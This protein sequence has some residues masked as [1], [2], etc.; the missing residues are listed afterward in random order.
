MVTATAPRRIVSHVLRRWARRGI[1]L[2]AFAIVAQGVFA[3]TAVADVSPVITSITPAQGSVVGGQ[4]V[5]ITGS[6]FVGPA[7][8]C[9]GE[10]QIAFG[11]D[12]VNHYA[13][14]A[15]SYQVL[16]DTQITAVVPANFGGQVDVRVHDSCGWSPASSGGVY[17]YDYPDSQCVS[18]T[19]SIAIDSSSPAPLSHAGVGFLDGFNTDAGVRITPEDTALVQALHPRQWR[20]GEAGL[21]APGGGVF[22]LAQQ[23]GAQVSLDLTSDW[24]DWAYSE[25]RQYWTT[26]YGD[27]S[28]YYSFIYN[29]VKHRMAANEAPAYFDVWNEPSSSGTVNQ[30]LSVYGTAYQA[31]KAADPSAQVVG[32]SIPSFLIAS[33]GHPDSPG[34][35]LSLTDFLNWEM[36]TGDRFAAIS[37]HEDGTTVQSSPASPGS[38]M[39]SMPL[40]GGYRDYWSPAAIAS[41]VLAAKALLAQY[42]ALSGTQIF[43]NEYGPT[44]AVNVPGWMVG[45]FQAL[46]TSGADEGMITCVTSDACGSLLDGLIGFDGTPQMPYWVMKAYSDM[47][48]SRLSTTSSGSNV[49]TLA[50]RDDSTQTIEALIGRADDCFGGDQCPEFHAI[51]DPPVTLSLSVA[52]PWGLKSVDVTLRAF[53]DSASNSI[54]HNDVP[55]AP[56]L[57]VVRGASVV[58]GQ[59]DLTIPS[60]D[61]GEALYLTITPS[62]TSPSTDAPGGPGTFVSPVVIA[63]GGINGNYPVP[64]ATAARSRR[65]NKHRHHH[66]HRN[67]HHHPHPHRHVRVWTG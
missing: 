33:G 62:S 55:S 31:I 27:L 26:P 39:A 20:L 59:V 49:Y 64:G 4:Q 56:K 42:P 63:P 50:S 14:E 7:N 17:T 58:N 23:S 43:V 28:T 32:P 22:T 2:C 67:H 34:Y 35:E 15:P 3:G 13:I 36:S 6:G 46:E 54:G 65:H 61:D 60:V 38:G 51:S 25:D 48:G 53:P 12:L 1:A 66:H 9:S 10:Y 47:T 11:F 16:S 8:A 52:I 24:E 29:D 19:C 41:H 45:D 21:N 37:W 5:T 18:G 30:W 57:T 40:P 44:Y